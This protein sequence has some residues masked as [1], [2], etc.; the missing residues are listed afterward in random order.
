MENHQHEPQVEN[1]DTENAV[2]DPKNDPMGAFLYHQRR[3]VEEALKAVDALLPDGFKEHGKESSNEFVTGFRVLGEA[4]A[5][6]LEKAG[7]ELDKNL[8]KAQN[9][10]D[11]NDQPSTTGPTKVKVKVD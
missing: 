2:P 3:A 5:D 1:Q 6:T 10:D 11:D 8:R 9:K 7:K 4:I